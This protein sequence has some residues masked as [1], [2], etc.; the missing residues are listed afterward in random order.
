MMMNSAF[1]SAFNAAFPTPQSVQH[2]KRVWLLGLTGAVLTEQDVRR[3]MLAMTTRHFDY[4]PKL[5]D[6]I[7]LCRIG[8]PPVSLEIAFYEAQQH[9]IYNPRHPGNWSHPVVYF[10]AAEVGLWDLKHISNRKETFAVFK[11]IY[12]KHMHRLALG[13]VYTLPEQPALARRRNITLPEAERKATNAKWLA[14]LR[15]TFSKLKE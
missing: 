8:N 5:C 12:E 11:K 4:V 13:H 9:D 7:E 14:K 1:G 10:I 15:E 2:A 6:F 3:G